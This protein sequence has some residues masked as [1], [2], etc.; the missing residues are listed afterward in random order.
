MGI[1]DFFRRKDKS[2]K[3]SKSTKYLNLSISTSDSFL[4]VGAIDFFGPFAKAPN[5]KYILAWQDFDYRGGSI[6]GN[7]ESG[8]GRAILISDNQLLYQVDLEMPNDGS[9]ANNG[10]AAIN[11]WRFGLNLDG[12]FYV[13]EKDGSKLIEHP[14]R[15]NLLKCGICEDGLLAWCKSASSEDENDSNKVFVFST[16]PPKLL[17][18]V[19][20][21]EI[22]ERIERTENEILI[23]LKGFNRRYT[24]DGELL[25]AEEVREAEKAY[26]IEHGSGYELFYLAERILQK[27]GPKE[28][29]ED[30]FQEIHALLTKALHK[31]ISDWY[32]AKIHRLLG[33]LAESQNDQVKALKHFT[34]AIEYDPKVGVKRALARL[35]KTLKQKKG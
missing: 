19:D 15:A 11:D 14:T 35:E 23:T 24:I 16:S 2:K 33:E 10:R 18:K 21:G 4:T 1:L 22:P 20:A 28:I 5:G 32:K 29:S 12:I 8:F 26:T 7:R 25:N 30:E 13:L 6:G 27:R 34:L 31:D 3:P 9:V 17:F